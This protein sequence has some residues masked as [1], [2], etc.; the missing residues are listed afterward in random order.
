MLAAS[1]YQPLTN[2]ETS[3]LTDELLGLAVGDGGG[4][5]P[6]RSAMSGVVFLPMLL[7][8]ET[9]SCERQEEKR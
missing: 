8:M 5:F 2:V 1:G 7:L 3:A 9:L 6:E 4:A